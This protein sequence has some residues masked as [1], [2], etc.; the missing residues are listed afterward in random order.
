M[1]FIYSHILLYFFTM[2][3]AY[4]TN[5]LQNIYS[6]TFIHFIMNRN[7]KYFTKH[8]YTLLNV[9]YKRRKHMTNIRL[10]EH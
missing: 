6:K 1:H 4:V 5:I 8:E 2:P 7:V 3:Y 10:L 9:N